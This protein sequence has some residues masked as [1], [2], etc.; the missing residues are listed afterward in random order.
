MSVETSGSLAYWRIPASGGSPAAPLKASFT[1]SR[2]AGRATSTTRSTIDPTG[3][4]ARIAIPSIFP[5]SSGRTVAE[6][7]SGP[8]CGRDQV[9]SPSARST[10]I[11]ARRVEHRL[12]RRVGMHRRHEAALDRKRIVENLGKWCDAVRRARGVRHDPV[13]C[14]VVGVVIDTEHDCYIS[15]VRDGRDHYSARH[16]RRGAPSPA[17]A[18]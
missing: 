8:G 18:L 6:R 1:S 14:W 10:Q 9:D 4:G 3:I 5:A 11:L 17:R 2:S 15:V 7:A 13:V 12:R 16:P